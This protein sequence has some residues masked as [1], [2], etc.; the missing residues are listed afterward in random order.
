MSDN[1]L[2]R[3]DDCLSNMGLDRN[4]IIE[5]LQLQGISYDL[6]Y[7]DA[8][9]EPDHIYLIAEFLQVPS[10]Y[11]FEVTGYKDHLV[12]A[13]FDEKWPNYAGRIQASKSEAYGRIVRDREFKGEMSGKGIRQE[14]DLL[15]Q[16]LIAPTQRM[17]VCEYPD[18]DDCYLRCKIMGHFRGP[19]D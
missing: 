18:C 6:S 4:S 8:F 13:I 3:V 2:K 19:E 16:G 12:W 17:V 14:I 1:L 5:F 9:A 10:S 15:L 7:L 11:L